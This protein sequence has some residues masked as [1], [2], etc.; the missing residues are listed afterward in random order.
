MLSEL[1]EGRAVQLRHGTTLKD[2]EAGLARL[3]N[4]GDALIAADGILSRPAAEVVA[5][6]ST[7]GTATPLST[8][9]WQVLA[10]SLAILILLLASIGTLTAP[11]LW[12]RSETRPNDYLNDPN[13]PLPPNAHRE[14]ST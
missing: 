13:W 7:V 2:A 3:R 1:E 10:P 11:Y 9:D 6:P 5:S 4:D 14:L 8:V 12:P